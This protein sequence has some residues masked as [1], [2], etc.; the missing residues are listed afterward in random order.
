MARPA[1]VASSRRSRPRRESLSGHVRPGRH[2]GGDPPVKRIAVSA[3]GKS[4]TFFFDST[5]RNSNEMRWVEYAWT[6]RQSPAGQSWSFAPWRRPTLI[7]ALRSTKCPSRP[8]SGASRASARPASRVRSIRQWD[9]QARGDG[10]GPNRGQR[11]RPEVALAPGAEDTL[12]LADPGCASD[13][14]HRTS[15]NQEPAPGPVIRA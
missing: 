10:D 15:L 2:P 4:A 14:S 8:C 3:A 12:R 1:T 5:G 7:S 6:S 13:P 9:E 11:G